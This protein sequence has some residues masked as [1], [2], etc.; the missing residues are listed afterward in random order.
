MIKTKLFSLYLLHIYIVLFNSN[1]VLSNYMDKEHYVFL[2]SR[3]GEKKSR[4]NL[5]QQQLILSKERGTG[6]QGVT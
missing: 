6:F 5:H 2:V 3:G 4:L 1:Y